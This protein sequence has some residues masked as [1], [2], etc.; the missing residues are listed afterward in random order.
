M[1][2]KHYLALGGA[3]VLILILYFAFDKAPQEI[4]GEGMSSSMT[5]AQVKEFDRG[6]LSASQKE[7]I[8]AL[9]DSISVAFVDTQKIELLKDLS[10]KWYQFGG[11]A[12]AG[13]TAEEIAQKENTGNAWGIAGTTYYLGMQRTTIPVVKAFCV[14]Q[15]IT[16]FESAIS[17]EPDIADH[18]INLALTYIDGQPAGEPPMKGILMLQD[19][20]KQD[21][22]NTQILLTLARLSV[23]RTRDY[24]KA[25]PRLRQILT[26][27]PSHVEAN[28]MIAQIYAETGQREQAVQAF[29]TARATTKDQNLQKQID[30]ILNSFNSSP[31][32]TSGD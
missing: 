5:A 30:N 6:R 32:Q 7:I 29:Q 10:G 19:Y 11:L 22:T 2:A 16:A 18:K 17:L 31:P 13:I 9:E 14:E 24:G 12:S 23:T 26:L 27:E 3:L 28:M 21:S 4:K 8:Q 25:L 1:Q 20:Q 15:A